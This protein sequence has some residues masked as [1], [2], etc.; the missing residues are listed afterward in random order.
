MENCY[1]YYFKI[2]TFFFFFFCKDKRDKSELATS[3][4]N[5]S[6]H[7]FFF[8]TFSFLFVFSRPLSSRSSIQPTND[9]TF[10]H[11]PYR[12]TSC[13][14]AKKIFFPFYLLVSSSSFFFCSL[15]SFLFDHIFFHFLLE[16]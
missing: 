5:N 16:I 2:M 4:N 11:D 13:R 15:F 14:D 3:N 6:H 1:H 7:L 8:Y 9:R 12:L 10:F